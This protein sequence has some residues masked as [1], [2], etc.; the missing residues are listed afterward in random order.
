MAERNVY[1]HNFGSI[2]FA[3]GAVPFCYLRCHMVLLLCAPRNFFTEVL[4]PVNSP[5]YLLDRGVYLAPFSDS[6]GI[7]YLFTIDSHRSVI[8]ST[9]VFPGDDTEAVADMCKRILDR[10]DPI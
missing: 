4:P 3:R 1:G 9:R 2:S 6:R 8:L 10:E 5:P 7:R